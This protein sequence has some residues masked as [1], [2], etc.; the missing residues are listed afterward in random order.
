MRQ[1]LGPVVTYGCESHNPPKDEVSLRKL[2]RETVRWGMKKKPWTDEEIENSNGQDVGYQDEKARLRGRN[3][4]AVRA[5]A[6]KH[7]W[8]LEWCKV[9]QKLDPNC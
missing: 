3:G 6:W 4:I 2:I 9:E 8:G 1:S 7:V 5:D